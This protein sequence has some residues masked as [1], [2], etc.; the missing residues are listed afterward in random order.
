MED[1]PNARGDPTLD[2]QAGDPSLPKAAAGLPPPDRPK[3]CPGV[4]P[5][6][7]RY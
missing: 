1:P 5:G 7:F 3:G 2:L 4:F 6:R